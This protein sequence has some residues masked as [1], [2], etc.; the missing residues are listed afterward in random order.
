L[1]SLPL[2]LLIFPLVGG[3]Y[4]TTRLE[5]SKYISQRLGS[6]AILFNAIL[7]SMPLLVVSLAIT[8]AATNVFPSHVHW[9]KHSLFPIK[10]EFFGTC[11]LSIVISFVGTQICNRWIK[12]SDAINSAIEQIG[13]ELELLFSYSC[14]ESQLIQITLKND[15]VYIGWVKVLPKPSHC[16]YV[17][18]IPLFSGYRDAQKELTI[19]TDYSRVYSQMIQRGRMRALDDADVNLVLEV[20]EIISASKFDF[21]LFEAFSAQG[22]GSNRRSN[23]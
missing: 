4:I 12:E 11:L 22:G 7:V 21:D 15:K 2:N 9:A 18:I 6:Q 23:P 8:T 20:N 5:S 3:Y 17:Q 14:N 1:E 10:Q 13:N 16:P 19:T